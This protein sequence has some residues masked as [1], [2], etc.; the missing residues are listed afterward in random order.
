MKLSNLRDKMFAGFKRIPDVWYGF[1]SYFIII[2]ILFCTFITL[3]QPARHR[4]SLRVKNSTASCAGNDNFL[5]A[6]DRFVPPHEAVDSN[7]G[8]D[9]LPAIDLNQPDWL[10]NLIEKI[11][12]VETGG[13]AA[14]PDGD[15]GLAC[16]PLQ[17]HS[18]IVDEVN[19]Y[20]NTRFSYADRYNIQKARQLARFY[21][22]FWMAQQKEEIAARIF[23][24]GPRGWS[25]CGTDEYWKKINIK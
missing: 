16:G 18:C 15:R 10:D 14:V 22:S 5:S 25:K 19:R 21:I 17:L 9:S 1:V 4:G 24:G 23:N 20:C 7:S 3:L 13:L 6:N 8:Q 2:G 11:R 12:F